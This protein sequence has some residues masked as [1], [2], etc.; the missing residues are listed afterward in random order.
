VGVFVRDVERGL[1]QGV[2]GIGGCILRWR[3]AV[4][5]DG[6]NEMSEIGMALRELGG[7]FGPWA[8]CLRAAISRA[9]ITV[10]RGKIGIAEPGRIDCLLSC[11]VARL[12]LQFFN[13]A[14]IDNVWAA[15]QL[16]DP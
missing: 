6:F 12:A 7:G 14:S 2:R 1:I 13:L 8:S 10:R 15:A 5:D 4:V 3:R 16:S 11:W 9:W